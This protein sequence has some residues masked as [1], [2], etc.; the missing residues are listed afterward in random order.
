MAGCTDDEATAWREDFKKALPEI[1]FM[2]PMVRDYRAAGQALVHRREIIDGDLE[3]IKRS[4][5]VVS[6]PWKQ[7][8]G[9]MM[10]MV[11]AKKIFH[12]KIIVIIPETREPSPWEV[13]HATVI[14]RSIPEAISALRDM[15]ENPDM[16][17]VVNHPSHYNA[18]KIEVS[19]FIKDQDLNF[20][21][22]NVVKYVCR[23]GKKDPAKTIED[24]KKARW[25]LTHEIESLENAVCSE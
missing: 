24:L 7:G 1:E 14:L 13:E 21:K 15:I 16:Q 12:K 6:F 17:D 3:D 9:T 19:D 8:A 18:G 4:D 11:Y 23:A 10:E 25:Y 5:V 22:G 2:D 20:N